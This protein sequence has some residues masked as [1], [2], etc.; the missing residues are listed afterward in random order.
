MPK[1]LLVDDDVPFRT[2]L[3]TTLT[4]LGYE[5]E[6]AADG[7]K[8]MKCFTAAPPDLVL[9][10]L[11]MPDREGLET[12]GEIRRLIPNVKV[13]AMS[14]GGRINAKDFLIVARYMGAN[15]TLAKPFSTGELAAMLAELLPAAAA[16]PP[17]AQ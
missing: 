1:I 5:V 7:A 9:T 8:A 17:T 11:I 3:R 16:V 10:D 14:G 12:I 4:K 2:M 13:I 15:R 6:E